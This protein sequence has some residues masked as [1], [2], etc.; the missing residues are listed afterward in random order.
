MGEGS[1]KGRSSNRSVIVLLLYLAWIEEVIV[2]CLRLQSRAP[3]GLS[4]LDSNAMSVANGCT[5]YDDSMCY[6]DLDEM[7]FIDPS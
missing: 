7:V 5:G 3:A 4:G 1:E 2:R 6:H